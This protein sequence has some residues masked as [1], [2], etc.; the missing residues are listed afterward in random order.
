M[1]RA[2]RAE[3]DGAVLQGLVYLFIAL[4]ALGVAAATYFGLTFTPIEA[5]VTAIAFGC[6]AILVV[7]R[8]LRRRAE[9]RL[10]K[11]VEDLS[12]LLSPDAQAGSLLS[13]RVNALTD[14]K[15]GPRLES[16]ESDLAVLG[17][18]IKQVPM[19]VDELEEHRRLKLDP[20]ESPRQS[21]E[22]DPDIM[23]EPVIPLE[24][25]RLAIDEHRQV[26]HIE[27]LVS[28]P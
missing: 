19:T 11:A 18:V 1:L 2:N 8:Q 26:Y 22:A 5:I 23:P 13:Q 15:A 10:E 9:A 24:L 17:T 25:L 7:E 20:S 4:A 16:I 14:L 21:T 28:L 12:R 6:L 27:P 3:S